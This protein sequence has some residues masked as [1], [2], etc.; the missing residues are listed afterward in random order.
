M[1]IFLIL[2]M[3]FWARVAQDYFPFNGISNCKTVL[4][5]QELNEFRQCT[6]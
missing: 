6:H 3:I 5:P 2:S 4:K 1:A